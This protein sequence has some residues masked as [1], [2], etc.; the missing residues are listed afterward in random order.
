[1]VQCKILP[2][3][4][5]YHP[6]LPY[7]HE[8]KLLFPL[9]KTCAQHGVKQHFQ[10][11]STQCHHSTE[12]R[13][14]IGTWTTKELEQAINKGYIITY[15]YEVWH[16]KEQT[17]QLFQPYIKTFMKIK[18]EASGWPVGCDTEEKKWD[19]LQDYEQHEGIRLDYNK[20]Q[21]NPGLRSLFKLMLNSF[22]GNSD[23]ALTRRKSPLAQN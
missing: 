2:T 5:L 15:I 8:S 10:E 21:K 16:F 4:G 20:V 11:R 23:N 1:M 7:R 13:A 12:E 22:G 3:Y 17:N 18:Q 9:C 19:Y 14:L 6:V